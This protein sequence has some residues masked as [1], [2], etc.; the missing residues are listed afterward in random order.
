MQCHGSACDWS[1]MLQSVDTSLDL[2]PSSAGRQG[3]KEPGNVLRHF[4]SSMY[5]SYSTSCCLSSILVLYIHARY[6]LEELISP[7]ARFTVSCRLT[8]NGNPTKVAHT[9]RG[10]PN[11]VSIGALRS[12]DSLM[13]LPPTISILAYAERKSR[14]SHLNE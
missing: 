5:Y 11:H 6:C 2:N 10:I 3:T 13:K 9:L 7:C 14:R 8:V 12:S 4:K 1:L